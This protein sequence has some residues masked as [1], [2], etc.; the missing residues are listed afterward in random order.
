LHA[1]FSTIRNINDV[2]AAID[3]MDFD[4]VLYAS[5]FARAVAQDD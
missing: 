4:G 3:H 5:P 2:G 1:L